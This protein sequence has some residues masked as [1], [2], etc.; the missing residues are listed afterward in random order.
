VTSGS[1]FHSRA[2]WTTAAP[3]QSEAVALPASWNST[4]LACKLVAALRVNIGPLAADDDNCVERVNIDLVD[5]GSV[6]DRLD[7][8]GILAVATADHVF[9]LRLADV[10][11]VGHGVALAPLGLQISTW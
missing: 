4:S 8:L 6:V 7:E 2:Y 5:T 1:P 10:F 9:L 3:W 11:G